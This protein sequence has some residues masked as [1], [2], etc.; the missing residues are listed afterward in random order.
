MYQPGKDVVHAWRSPAIAA[1]ALADGMNVVTSMG[2]YLTAGD[3][4][5]PAFDCH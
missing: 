2:Y 3:G 1:Q 5:P 4:E